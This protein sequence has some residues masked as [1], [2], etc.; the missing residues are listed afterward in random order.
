MEAKCK[1][2][3]RT[4]KPI[5]AYVYSAY[6][7]MEKPASSTWCSFKTLEEGLKKFEEIKPRYQDKQII[8]IDF[9][10]YPSRILHILN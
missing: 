4:G 10:V 5:R 8:F 7:T 2:K 9:G 1:T 3:I 6:A